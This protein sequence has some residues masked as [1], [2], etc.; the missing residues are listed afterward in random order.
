MKKSSLLGI[1]FFLACFCSQAQTLSSTNLQGKVVSETKD[2]ADVHVLNTTTKKATITN[3]Y[4]YFSIPVR[5]N[6][7]LVFSAVQ[8][9]RKE[10]VISTSMLESK[11]IFVTLEEGLTELDEVVVMPYNLSGTLDQDVE[12]LET[13]PVVTASTL[14]LPNAYVKPP[15]KAERELYEAVSGAGLVPLNPILNAISGRTKMLKKRLARDKKYART[16][17]VRA[18]YADSLFIGE[19]KIPEAKIDDFMYFCE[20]DTEFSALVDTHDRLKIW[21]FLRQKSV[22]YRENNGLE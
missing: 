3:A 16:G 5:L 21:S 8:F 11:I 7:T 9:K 2:I 13:E 18:F 4:G 19:L 12:N 17:R 15:T 22:V 20:V 1:Y 10:M 6:D 14:G